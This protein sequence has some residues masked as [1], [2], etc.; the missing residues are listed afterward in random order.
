MY[1]KNCGEQLNENQDIC[2]KC[3]VVVGKGNSY[4]QN[5]G[6]PISADAEY[7]MNCGVKVHKTVASAST[8]ANDAAPQ[9][10]TEALKSV[11]KRDLVKAIIFSIL[12]CGIYQIYWFIV[13]TDD[14][15]RISG[16]ENDMS[17]LV[18]FLLDLVTCGIYG[19]VW[20]YFMGGKVDKITG[21]KDTY[22]PI[23]YLILEIFGFNIINLALIQDTVN[24][25][26]DN[27]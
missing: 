7:C 8:N 9:V 3:G 17:G 21:A 25:A 1:C 22:T 5:C 20:A 2:V 19:C 11:Q 14:V 18:S 16:Q 10:N 4:C 6:N 12:T 23:I 24:K 13:L 15:N 26:V 27:Q